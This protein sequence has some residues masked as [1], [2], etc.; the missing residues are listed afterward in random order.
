MFGIKFVRYP[1]LTTYLCHKYLI[2]T[3]KILYRILADILDI[4]IFLPPNI[5]IGIGH[6]IAHISQALI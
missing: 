3:F 1:A 6:K 2:T 5:G 4:R